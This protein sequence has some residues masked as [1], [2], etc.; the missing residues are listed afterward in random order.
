[1]FGSKKN[2]EERRYYL[3]P[4]MGKANRRKRKTFLKWSIIVGTIVS[5]ILGTL[6]YYLNN[7]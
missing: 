4:G 5:A 2:K 7:P 3:L 6:I 1:M